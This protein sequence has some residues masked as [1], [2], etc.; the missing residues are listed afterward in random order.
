MTVNKK[1][2]RESPW[3]SSAFWHSPACGAPPRPLR[4]ATDSSLFEE[5]PQFIH[6][7]R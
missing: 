3:P 7:P 1:R 2:T 6:R 5:T 4:I